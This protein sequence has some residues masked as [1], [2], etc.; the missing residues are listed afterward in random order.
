VLLKHRGGSSD[1]VVFVSR[2]PLAMLR[3]HKIHRQR[4]DSGRRAIVA[5]SQ[6][7]E[8]LERSGELLMETIHE[9]GSGE[10]DVAAT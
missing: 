10:P 5:L 3:R 1:V 6:Q 2:L 7:Q 4:R 8:T 9:T